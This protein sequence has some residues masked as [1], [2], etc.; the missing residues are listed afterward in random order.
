VASLNSNKDRTL[1]DEVLRGKSFAVGDAKYWERP[2]D[3]PLKKG[4]DAFTNKNPSF[5]I[6]FYMQHAGMEWG[7]LTN[8]RLWRLYHK[9][10]AHKLDRFYE[11]DLPALV[12]SE[13]AER[14]LFFYAFFN[15]SAFEDH[16]LGLRAMLAESLDYARSV[17]NSLKDQV[18]EALRHVAQGFLDYPRNALEAAPDTLREI[19]DNSLI[20]LYRLLFILY[21]ESRDLLPL[22]ESELYRDT[23]SLH[24]I[25]HDVARGRPLLSTSA[26]LWPKIRE[27]YRIINEGSPPLKVVTFNGGLFDP[28]RHPFLEHYTVGYG[29]LQEAIDK[30]SR[31]GGQFV[32]Y[33]DL[34]ERHLGTIYE[35][36]LEYHLEAL[37]EP[38]E[39]WSVALLNNR[40]ER[41]AS[42][43]YYTP[44]FVVKYIV[45]QTLEPL[46][47]EAVADKDTDEEKV[48]ALLALN[49]LDPSMG[50]GHFL[51]EATER[52]ARFLVE[53]DVAPEEIAR[54]GEAELAYWKR[55]VAQSCVYGVELNPLAVDLAKLSLW[56]ATVAKDRP[57]SFLDHHLRCGN[58]LVGARIDDLQIG[59]NCKK[60]K[61]QRD[62][63][64]QLSMLGD[65]A[66][67]SSMSTAVGSMWTIEENPAD[68]VQEVKEQERIYEIVREEHSRRYA[69]LSDL[70][71]ATYFGVEI[72]RS[73][74]EPFVDFAA[75]RA[76]YA[77][78]Q[79][80]R[81]LNEAEKIAAERRFFHWEVE[82]PEVFFDRQGRMLGEDAGFDAI[83]GNPPYVQAKHFPELKPYLQ[84]AYSETYK[85]AADL[86][87]YFFQFGLSRLK[88]SGRMGYIS[89]GLFSKLD[90]GAP[91]RQ[92]LTSI[93]TVLEIVEFGEE[94]VFEGAV[95]YPIILSLKNEL[96]KNTVTLGLRSIT[97]LTNDT[98]P[99][100]NSIPKA[101]D[102]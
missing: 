68:T 83:V 36:L 53:L 9:D 74:W 64:T 13:D 62:D 45:D 10:T 73:L 54:A 37:S 88:D 2:L 29:H 69:R 77:P 28:E 51:V 49:V 59:S 89:S 42:G 57:L 72:D 98:L 15:R 94:Q 35:G 8:G 4:S 24:A 27:L 23:Y 55:R 16:P 19:Y 3:V 32:D 33:Q 78:P 48:E 14:F 38:E 43:S 20:L 91:L 39:G 71:T 92:F 40:G 61:K 86:Y 12:E 93:S 17:G 41:K 99:E 80:Q 76:P 31:V 96:P 60:R 90:Y 95:T 30:L 70:A 84:A 82:F 58:S 100:P 1:S 101:D 66:F 75:G 46:L 102:I 26:T 81:W 85:G 50:S 52:I 47:E 7:I 65:P 63:D 34:A 44:D 11:V 6:A 67:Q 97:D 56:L 87:V 21:A 5:Q 18:Y 79:F 22:Y 25:K